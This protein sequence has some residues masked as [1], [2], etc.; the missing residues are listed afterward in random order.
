MRKAVLTL[1]LAALLPA[2]AALAHD[3]HVKLGSCEV[4]EPLDWGARHDLA[5]ARYAMLTEDR[6]VA[7]VLTGDVVAFQLSDRAFRDLDRDIAR[8]KHDDEDDVI[9]G[10]IKSAILGG[11]RAL[12]DHS[13]ECPVEDL[14]DVRYRDGRLILITQD[15]DRIFEDL[16]IN[17]NEVLESFSE[18]DAQV[19]AREFRRAKERSR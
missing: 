2:G 15:G 19:F 13:L 4:R 14:R 18:H 10:A 16:S 12:L 7:L 11:V 1:I 8:E 17:D 3:H 5:R 9:G 6:A